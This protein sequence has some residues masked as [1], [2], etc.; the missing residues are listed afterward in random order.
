MS[1]RCVIRDGVLQVEVMSSLCC[2][3]FIADIEEFFKSKCIREISLNHMLEIILLAFA[4]D[5]VFIADSPVWLKRIIK[6]LEE[7]FHINSLEV[8]IKRKQTT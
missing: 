6:A 5:M 8:N 1:G 4:D 2:A 3:L 7:Y